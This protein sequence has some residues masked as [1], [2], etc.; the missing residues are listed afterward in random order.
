MNIQGEIFKIKEADDLLYPKS[1]LNKLG[2]WYSNDTTNHPAVLKS[3]ET[4]KTASKNKADIITCVWKKI[5]LNI[6]IIF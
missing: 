3:L 4:I 1:N 5:S 2:I 6:F